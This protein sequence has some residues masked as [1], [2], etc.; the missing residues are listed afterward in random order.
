MKERILQLKKQQSEEEQKEGT[1]S[2]ESRISDIR[3]KDRR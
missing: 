3:Q 1:K 2:G